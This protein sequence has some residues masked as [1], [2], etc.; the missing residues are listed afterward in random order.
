M[1]GNMLVNSG[2]ALGAVALLATPAVA[3]TGNGLGRVL[4]FQ[5]CASVFGPTIGLPSLQLRVA[6]DWEFTAGPNKAVCGG[7][8]TGAGGIEDWNNPPPNGDSH[9]C[10]DLSQFLIGASR[11]DCSITAEGELGAVGWVASAGSILPV[12]GHFSDVATPGG[13]APGS[14]P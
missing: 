12:N 13:D 9:V 10:K 7:V 8:A 2:A 4:I 5:G 6:A 14:V 11:F 1:M 3:H